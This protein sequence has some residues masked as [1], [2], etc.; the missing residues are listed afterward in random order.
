MAPCRVSRRDRRASKPRPPV[1]AGSH[2]PWLE[3]SL[4]ESGSESARSS[5]AAS[6]A[7]P[8]SPPA[9]RSPPGCTLTSPPRVDWNREH[10]A[11]AIAGGA[12][13]T[14]GVGLAQLRGWW[15]C[16]ATP[17]GVPGFWATSPGGLPDPAPAASGQPPP[18][19]SS[20]PARRGSSAASSGSALDLPRAAVRP[21]SRSR[22]PRARPMPGSRSRPWR[23]SSASA[24]CRCSANATTS[25]SGGARC[26]SGRCSSCWRL[27][28]AQ[29]F[30]R[31]ARPNSAATTSPAS[32]PCATMVRDG[33]R[34]RRRAQTAGAWSWRRG[35]R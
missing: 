2:D 24:S 15:C 6:T 28:R 23:A 14:A 20:A 21:T 26:S 1:V 17:A 16:S 4:R 8:G 25:R 9:R 7:L 3:W 10:V 32:A 18:A 19:R 13:G 35:Q 11:R 22:S 27:S 34:R 31:R 5:T 33:R 29:A 12:G 30:W